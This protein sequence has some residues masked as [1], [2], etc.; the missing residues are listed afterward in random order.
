M[1]LGSPLP[2]KKARLEI[3]PLIDIMFFLL[4][5]FMMVSVTMIRVQAIKMDLP[6]ATL[7]DQASRPEIVNIQV[8]K[9]GDLYLGQE[10]M[11]AVELFGYLTN[12]VRANAGLP[13]YISGDRE[14]THGTVIG[15]LELVRRAGVQKVSFA[16]TRPAGAE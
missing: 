9:R 13:V 16:I 2:R 11:T 10:R 15:V 12:R 6:A 5:A 7:A 14:A 1:K 8:D 3:I 4:A